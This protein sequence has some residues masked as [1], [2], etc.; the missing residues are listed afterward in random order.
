MKTFKQFLEE[1]NLENKAKKD[2]WKQE[3]NPRAFRADPADRQD[4]WKKTSYKTGS[5]GS[6]PLKDG[7]K[8]GPGDRVTEPVAFATPNKPNALYAFPRRDSGGKI[9]PAASVKKPGEKK[10]VIYTTKKG[11]RTLRKTP[12]QISS[13]SAKNFDPIGKHMNYDD[14][15]EIATTKEPQ[16]TKRTLVKNPEGFVRSQFDI[17][18]KSRKSIRKLARKASW[19]NPDSSITVQD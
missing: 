9:V 2:A 5:W 3:T 13:A 18:V 1:R 15:N 7:E 12:V 10:G 11:L 14:P 19:K 8:A 17:Q 6:A 16:D 4:T